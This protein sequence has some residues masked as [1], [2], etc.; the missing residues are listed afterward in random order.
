MIH[1]SSV[2]VRTYMYIC[3]VKEIFLVYREVYL[4]FRI[5]LSGHG[6]MDEQT[7]KK[8]DYA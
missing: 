3:S 8:H 7:A 2:V 6:S 1:E 5:W 4:D